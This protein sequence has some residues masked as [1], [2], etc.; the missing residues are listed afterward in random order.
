MTPEEYAAKIVIDEDC[1][2]PQLRD[3]WLLSRIAVAI[4]Q[5]IDEAH[6]E[7]DLL[8]AEQEENQDMIDHAL[9]LARLA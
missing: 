2:D 4:R 6:E 8:H 3:P 7:F 9:R 1:V 5:V